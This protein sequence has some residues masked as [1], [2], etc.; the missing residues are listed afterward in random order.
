MYLN[1]VKNNY[2]YNS[3]SFKLDAKE[4]F[5]IIC[6]SLTTSCEQTIAF[7]I[8]RNDEIVVTRPICAAPPIAFVHG[9]A[10]TKSERAIPKC[11]SFSTERN[12]HFFFLLKEFPFKV[13]RE[14]ECI[15]LISSA[16]F[17]P[18][19]RRK[20]SADSAL[21]SFQY[22]HDWP[23]AI[24][25]FVEVFLIPAISAS[26]VEKRKSCSRF[27]E[28]E[29]RFQECNIF[30]T[31]TELRILDIWFGGLNLST[32][33]VHFWQLQY[34]DGAILRFNIPLQLTNLIL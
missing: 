26:S 27:E 32:L 3:I 29:T 14:K 30:L 7:I 10:L 1:Q 11:R 12:K 17:C 25:I 20:T 4:G 6:L 34:P 19:H 23:F 21:R 31:Q 24:T 33:W 9:I 16:Y 13:N 2:Y 15:L 28:G 5:F 18:A 22:D 8:I